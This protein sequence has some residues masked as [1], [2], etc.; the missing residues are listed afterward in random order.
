MSTRIGFLGPEGTFT[1]QALASLAFEGV[2]EQPVATVGAVLEAVRHGDVAAGLVPMENSIEGGVSATL[3][4][5]TYGTPLVITREVLLPVQFNLYARPGATLADVRRIATHPHAEAQCRD[6]LARTLP[7]AKVTPA[8]S[9]A[10][11]AEA[12]AAAGADAPDAAIC[13]AIAG[14][15]LGLTPLAT[16][17]ADNTGAVTRFVLVAPAG[18]PPA[19]TRHDKTTLVVFLHEDAAGGLLGILQEFAIRGINLS[20]IE[21]R[22]S[23]LV[24]GTYSFCID[25]LG[26]VA[27][28]RM[29]EALKGLK[30]TAA[31]VVF[32]GSYPAAGQTPAAT[33]PAHTDQAHAAAESW[34]AGLVG[35]RT[36]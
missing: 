18:P 12:V 14:E 32:L 8:G 31:D 2:A 11:G 28:A 33:E 34:Y 36:P 21:S 20:R 35:R 19:P 15:R 4:N 27:E 26:H 17:I 29:A 10:A 22:P 13:A 25:A 24:R 30:R 5:L 7:Q 23:R 16:E 3:D 1:H 6:W 9:T